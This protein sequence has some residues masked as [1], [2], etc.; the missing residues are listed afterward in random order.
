MNWIGGVAQT[1]TV[2]RGAPIL[3]SGAYSRRAHVHR[4]C[5]SLTTTAVS[6]YNVTEGFFLLKVSGSSSEWSWLP[7]LTTHNYAGQSFAFLFFLKGHF[8]WTLSYQALT[9]LGRRH[10]FSVCSCTGSLKPDGQTRLLSSMCALFLSRPRLQRI[11]RF[12]TWPFFNFKVV[13][14]RYSRI[15][16]FFPPVF[17]FILTGHRCTTKKEQYATSY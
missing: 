2:N 8:L 10:G 11:K 16:L 17:I 13:C 4:Y 9:I 14:C 12:D 6:L 7:C 1:R 3:G 5:Q 15:S